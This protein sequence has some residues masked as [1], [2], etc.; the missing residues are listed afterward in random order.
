MVVRALGPSLATRGVTSPLQDP[1]LQLFDGSG[2]LLASNSDWMSNINVQAISDSG[3]APIDPRESA[4]LVALGP[5]TYTAI[6][7]GVDGTANNIGEV[8]EVLS[9]AA[10]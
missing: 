2:G 7:T 5:G 6:V 4:L 3:L 1:S 9:K 10:A 8:A